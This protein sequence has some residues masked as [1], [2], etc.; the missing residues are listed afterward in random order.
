MATVEANVSPELAKAIAGSRNHIEEIARVEAEASS[1]GDVAGTLNM[2]CLVSFLMLVENLGRLGLVRPIKMFHDQ[3]HTYGEGYKRI[4]QMH[5]GMPRLFARFPHSDMAY[6]NIEHIAEFELLDSMTSM[7]IQ[8]ADLLAGAI[9]HCCRLAM[10]SEKPTPGDHALAEGILP[11]LLVATPRLTWLVCSEHCVR[12]LGDRVLKPAIRALDGSI[13][14][15]ESEKCVVESLA[16]MFPIKGEAEIADGRERVRL[17]L[18]LFGLAVMDGGALIVVKNP[19]G[20]DDPCQR[21]LLLFTSKDLAQKV[22]SIWNPDEL[23]RPQK[24]AAFGPRELPRFI[25]LL[26]EAA[27]MTDYVA[28]DPG[29]DGPLRMAALPKFIDDMKRMLSRIVRTYRSGMDKV[30]VEKHQFGTN[31]VLSMQSKNGQYAAMIQPE[32]KIY[33]AG[34]REEAIDKLRSAEGI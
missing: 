6:M 31:E 3:Q 21:Y 34:S 24:V 19:E 16:P 13:D 32:G 23:N 33:F 9:H 2:P 25:E 15:A 27:T 17:D 11:G 28:F 5:K 12:A 7:P 26:E 20:A 4:F 8:A 22:L 18:P 29:S 1:L 14:E 10:G 30:I